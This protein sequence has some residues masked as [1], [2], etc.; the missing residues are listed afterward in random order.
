[1]NNDAKQLTLNTPCPEYK[2]YVGNLVDTMPRMRTEGRYPITV[3]GLMRRRLE[4]ANADVDLSRSWWGVHL[5]TGDATVVNPDG[6]IKIVV[7]DETLW[8][9][10]PDN[11]Q[12]PHRGIMVP[13]K[14]VP[15][16]NKIEGEEFTIGEVMF[17][18]RPQTPR[19]AKR[20]PIWRALAQDKDR[21][22]D[23]VDAV[24]D[25]VERVYP[26]MFKNVKLMPVS[27]PLLGDRPYL[28]F[29]RL[30]NGF[31]DNNTSDNK[32]LV[33]LSTLM[34]YDEVKI[35]GVNHRFQK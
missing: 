20:N 24:Y 33:D 18:S 10:H 21:L 7:D 4:V 32:Y 17:Y 12:V 3:A 19:Q 15:P 23:Y 35:V 1:M 28:S 6:R 5:S 25:R 16:Y 11:R 9:F 31:P 22:S 8:A 29:V 2:L 34:N 27:A 13:S 30:C 26:R 14:D